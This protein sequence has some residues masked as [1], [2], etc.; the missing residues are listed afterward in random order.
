M[1]ADPDGACMLAGSFDLSA[2]CKSTA[3]LG[4]NM[5]PN[6]QDNISGVFWAAFLLFSWTTASI[7]SGA[8]I[9]RVRLAA[10]LLL[11]VLLGSVVWILDAA[12]GWSAGGWLVT[13]WGFHDAIASGV[14]HGV[15]GAFTLGVLLQ[16]GPRIGKYYENGQARS[17]LP[18][19]LHLTLLGLMLIF[20]GFYAF[21][22]ACLVIQSTVVPRLGQ[23]LP[24][25]RRRSRR[26]RSRSPS[27]S[28]AGSRAA[29]SPA[30][31]TRSGCCRAA[32][33]A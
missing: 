33:P 12:W 14:V 13:D 27:A 18:H 21:Y 4:D 6:L 7:M 3:R 31:A 24:V 5:G 22:A 32:W 29:T 30:A 15:A 23:H 8:L 11:T 19:N 20:T 17:F 2:F 16:L 26:S 10:Y 25:A 1:P 9:E 28:R